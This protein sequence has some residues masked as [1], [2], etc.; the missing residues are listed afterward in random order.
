VDNCLQNDKVF[1]KDLCNR[2][3]RISV[4]DERQMKI[5]DT[6]NKLVLCSS[7]FVMYFVTIHLQTSKDNEVYSKGDVIF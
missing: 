1:F 4:C 3:V 2:S 7:L 5:S 6:D